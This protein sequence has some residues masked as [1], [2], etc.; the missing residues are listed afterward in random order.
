MFVLRTCLR[1]FVLGAVPS[2]C[3]GRLRAGGRPC[4]CFATVGYRLTHTLTDSIH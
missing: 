4:G 1:G 2:L 3:Y